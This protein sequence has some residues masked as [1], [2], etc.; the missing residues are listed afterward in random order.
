MLLRESS[1]GFSPERIFEMA[2]KRYGVHQLPNMVRFAT[3]K[4]LIICS[5]G[6][7]TEQNHRKTRELHKF[8][9]YKPFQN[10]LA[11]ALLQRG[12]LSGSFFSVSGNG[13]PSD[14]QPT[15]ECESCSTVGAMNVSVRCLDLVGGLPRPTTR[16]YPFTTR[17][18]RN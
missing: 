17:T 14:W 13:R 8:F 3:R 5:K 9:V 10:A 18:T 15:P 11:R 16:N 4:R 12:F 2:Q 6:V 1:P 7:P